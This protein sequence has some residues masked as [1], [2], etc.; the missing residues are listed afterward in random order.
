MDLAA[1][2]RTDADID[3]LRALLDN[4]SGDWTTAADYIDKEIAFHNAIADASGNKLLGQLLSRFNQIRR[5]ASI[6]SVSEH[7]LRLVQSLKSHQALFDAILAQ[8]P[9]AGRIAMAHDID[10]IWPEID[11]S[12]DGRLIG[13]I[14]PPPAS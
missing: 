7:P 5:I 4:L 12:A 2:R 11:L 8:D 1:E 3:R 6:V 14:E 10:G 9:E 13:Q